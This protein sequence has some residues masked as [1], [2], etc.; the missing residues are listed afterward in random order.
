MTGIGTTGIIGNLNLLILCG[1]K[2]SRLRPV[3]RGVPK[4]MAD[5]HGRPFLDILITYAAG[6][7]IKRFI[8]G[9][10]YKRKLIKA[11]YNNYHK[12]DIEIGFSEETLPLGTGGAVGNSSHFLQ[13]NPFMVMNGDSFCPLNIPE[14][15]SFHKKKKA[16]VSIALVRT[17]DTAEY[18]FIN[19]DSFSR[20]TAFNEKTGVKKRGFINAGVYLFDKEI[21]LHLPKRETF[22]LEYDFFPRL[23]NE[24]FYGYVTRAKLVDIGTPDRYKKALGDRILWHRK[25]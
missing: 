3:L 18:G 25:N 1:G 15:I 7:G 4:P 9:I 24:R 2:G 8:L 22:S 12:N 17:T 19:L 5:I 14:F 21:F 6:Y 23:V 16:L 13:S 20:V 11:Y 10:G